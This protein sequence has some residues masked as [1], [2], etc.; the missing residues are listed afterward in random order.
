MICYNSLWYNNLEFCKKKRRKREKYILFN[1][2]KNYYPRL[3]SLLF[4]NSYPIFETGV[5]VGIYMKAF[6]HN[7]NGSGVNEKTYYRITNYIVILMKRKNQKKSRRIASGAVIRMGSRLFNWELF[8]LYGYKRDARKWTTPLSRIV[9]DF[10]SISSVTASGRFSTFNY[11][12]HQNCSINRT[13]KAPFV[14]DYF[15]SGEN[16]EFPSIF[17]YV[18]T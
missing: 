2:S 14:R 12:T 6:N 5:A 4:P 13:K 10:A 17:I 7:H 1:C 3:L 15:R 9:L 18:F 16:Q 11:P 8:I